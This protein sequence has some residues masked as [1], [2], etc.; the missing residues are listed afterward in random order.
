MLT[1]RKSADNKH[2]LWGKT[3][4]LASLDYER[5]GLHF[6]ES[7][8]RSKYGLK[9][10]RDTYGLPNRKPHQRPNREYSGEERW[11]K[12]AWQYR[13]DEHREHSDLFCVAWRDMA[14]VNF[15]LS[16]AYFDSLDHN[17]FNESLTNLLAH[18]HGL[19]EVEDLKEFDQQAGVYLMVF[20]E[21]KTMYI[22]QST[23]IRKRVKKHWVGRKPFDRLIFGSEFDSVFPVDEF[24]SLDNSR[25]YALKTDDY[26]EVERELAELADR[27]FTLNRIDGGLVTLGT[28]LNHL[29]NPRAHT[30][31]VDQHPLTSDQ[32]LRALDVLQ[33][34]LS[35]T[36]GD[37]ESLLKEMAQ[38]PPH[39]YEVTRKDGSVFTWTY[40]K[41]I[42]T[43][44]CQG[45][46]TLDEYL[47]YLAHLGESPILLDE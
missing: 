24:R 9:L 45:K 31:P 39:F 27:R 40:R 22:G 10:S 36:R 21:Y 20:D 38:L 28:T 41:A 42:R 32:Y 16:M 4:V 47:L 29:A 37:K 30:A 13:D 3:M 26:Y 25:L 7:L 43:L 2:D 1:V 12:S 46:I 19:E 5:T 14:L 6:G 17:E 35:N 44:A 8:R 33:S 18:N 11:Q 23:D 15:D 34:Q